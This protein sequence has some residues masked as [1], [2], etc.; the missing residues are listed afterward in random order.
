MKRTKYVVRDG[1]E[2]AR[3]SS[4]RHACLFG[5]MLSEHMPWQ[6]IEVAAPDGLVGQYRGGHPTSEFKQHHIDNIFV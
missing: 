5:A 3:F 6:L 4:V 1:N 2:I